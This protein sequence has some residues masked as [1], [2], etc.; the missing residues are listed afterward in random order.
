VETPITTSLTPSVDALIEPIASPLENISLNTLTPLVDDKDRNAP[1]KA[2]YDEES[3]VT[4][5]GPVM[6]G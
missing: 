2:G 1:P 4:P 3:A 6:P 5:G